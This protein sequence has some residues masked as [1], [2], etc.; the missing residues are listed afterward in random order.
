MSAVD[1]DGNETAGVRLPD[2]AAPVATHAGW[3]TRAP[4]TGAPEQIVPMQGLTLFF[5]PEADSR[6][7]AG[8]SRASLRERY[9]SRDEYL[10][11]VR[12][13]AL[14]LAAGRYLLDE[15]VD[16]VVDACARRYDAA[17]SE[18]IQPERMRIS[19]DSSSSV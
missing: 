17:M 6:K 10:D 19:M 15:D 16:V 2:I 1:S 8:D 4:E 7:A 18:V 5:A 3:N 13:H 9:G 14:G 12:E 11:R